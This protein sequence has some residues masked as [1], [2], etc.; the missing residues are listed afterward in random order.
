[1]RVGIR[2][3]SA[4]KST[5]FQQSLLAGMALLRLR[6]VLKYFTVLGAPGSRFKRKLLVYWFRSWSLL[7]VNRHLFAACLY[8]LENLFYRSC[9]SSV[10][11]TKLTVLI[12]DSWALSSCKT[13]LYSTCW[14]PQD[15]SKTRTVFSF[16][17]KCY[18]VRAWHK[19]VGV[20]VSNMRALR[21][22]QDDKVLTRIC[23]PAA[24]FEVCVFVFC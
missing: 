15:R 12:V 19:W 8:V 17:A 10:I 13:A 3:Y 22:R 11:Y 7:T 18:R 4:G 2:A 16:Y 21:W 20:S 9:F 23:M 1:M 24:T 6:N 14:T 5:S